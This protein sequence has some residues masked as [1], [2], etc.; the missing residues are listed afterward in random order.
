[1]ALPPVRSDTVRGTAGTLTHILRKKRQ[2]KE[3]LCVVL[4]SVER[5]LLSR[6]SPAADCFRPAGCDVVSG[7]RRVPSHLYA[8]VTT[9]ATNGRA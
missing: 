4:I 5:L 2:I 7:V 3:A 9:A 8:L 6:G 1:M